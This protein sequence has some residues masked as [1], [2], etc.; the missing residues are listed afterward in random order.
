MRKSA[1]PSKTARRQT[2]WH[3][4]EPPAPPPD[5]KTVVALEIET[6]ALEL[7]AQKGIAEVTVEQIAEKAGISRRTFYRY[8]ETPEDVLAAMPE[9]LLERIASNLRFRPIGEDISTSFM[10]AVRQALRLTAGC[11][12]P[13]GAGSFGDVRP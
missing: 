13:H 5:R 6:A 10:A 11:R 4:Y 7:F 9:R 3:P 8:F 2:G 1:P 12:L